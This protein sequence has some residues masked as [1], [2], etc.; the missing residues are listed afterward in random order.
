M[1]E[2]TLS[3]EEKKRFLRERR[4]AKMAN[5]KAS[6]RLNTILS[7]GSQMEAHAVS[8]LDSKE[9][10]A[11]SQIDGKELNIKPEDDPG[12]AD[13]EE[14]TGTGR[15]DDANEQEIDKM[16]SNVLHR[17][18]PNSGEDN[19]EFSRFMESL[20]GQPTRPNSQ[21]QESKEE[22]E[23]A[24]Q[25]RGYRLQQKKNLKASLL[26]FRYLAITVNFFYHYHKA[27]GLAFQ[28]SQDYYIRGYTLQS[29]NGDFFLWFTT[30]EV[31]SL[32]FL[33]F[34]S[35]TKPEIFNMPDDSLILKGISFASSVL[36]NLQDYQPIVN[37]LLTLWDLVSSIFSDLS[38][39]VV[40]FGLCIFL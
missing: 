1:A 4:Q 31:V 27:E 32:A 23:Y 17:N 21:K 8:V 7:Q 9:Y 37:R 3:N 30:I 19:D 22:I 40:L 34:Q 13:I 12:I 16:L 29:S 38:L 36:P 28:P 20:M 33:Y 14:V 39:V 15:S 35:V 2:Q 24:E 25:L 26:I 6:N 5:G 10:P 18:S 11:K